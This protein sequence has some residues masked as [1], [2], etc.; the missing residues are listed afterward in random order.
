M[1]LLLLGLQS[2]E[3][4]P[5]QNACANA[6]LRDRVQRIIVLTTK[7]TLPDS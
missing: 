7:E 1:C 5:S 2:Y 3:D 6:P 4:F